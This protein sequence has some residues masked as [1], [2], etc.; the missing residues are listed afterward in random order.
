MVTSTIQWK[1]LVEN[2]RFLKKKKTL[3][4]SEILTFKRMMAF[5]NKTL[6]QL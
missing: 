3:K 4:S 2:G 5:K 6:G 1:K